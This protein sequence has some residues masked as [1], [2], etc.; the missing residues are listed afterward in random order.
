MKIEYFFFILVIPLGFGWD[1]MPENNT[2][3]RSWLVCC[4]GGAM[5]T[6]LQLQRDVLITF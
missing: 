5:L 4:M 3:D 6:K 2:C 1:R